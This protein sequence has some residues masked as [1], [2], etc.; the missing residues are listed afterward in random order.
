MRQIATRVAV[1]NEGRI[2]EQG[3]TAQVFENPVEEYTPALLKAV[4]VINP[5]WEIRRQQYMGGM[6]H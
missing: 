6:A 4:P 1:M 5:E 2:V 3:A